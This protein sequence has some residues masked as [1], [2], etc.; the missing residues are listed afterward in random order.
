MGPQ[1]VEATAAAG[2]AFTTVSY[3]ANPVIIYIDFMAYKLSQP[4]RDASREFHSKMLVTWGNA[5]SYY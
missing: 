3:V 2:I 5:C 4:P 1:R